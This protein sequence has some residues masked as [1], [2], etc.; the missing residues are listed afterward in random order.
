MKVRTDFVTNSS[1]SSFVI[2]KSAITAKQRDKI[3]F[4]YPKLA[5][6]ETWDD[7][8]IYEREHLITGYTVMDNGEM[9]DYLKKIGVPNS[10]VEWIYRG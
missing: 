7:W 6:S 10:A 4:E 5:E 9:S 1:S 8:D 2:A 3:L